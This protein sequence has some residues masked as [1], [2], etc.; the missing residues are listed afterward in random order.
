MKLSFLSTLTP[1]LGL[2]M[3]SSRTRIWTAEEGIVLDEATVLA[4]DTFSQKVVAVGDEAESMAGRVSNKVTIHHPV[5]GGRLYDSDTAQ[6]LL[7][8]FFQ[9]ALKGNY[10]LRPIIMAS[11]SADS[12]EADRMALSALLYNVGARE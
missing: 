5:P 7:K 3:G 4:V 11:V 10:F 9:K 1:L 2:D 12:T 8:V 6:A